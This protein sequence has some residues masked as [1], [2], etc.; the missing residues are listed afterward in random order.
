MPVDVRVRLAHLHHEVPPLQ[1]R[2]LIV[3]KPLRLVDSHVVRQLTIE[4]DVPRDA[5]GEGGL[6]KCDLHVPLE[7]G[8]LRH[9]HE[10]LNGVR[11]LSPNAVGG[12]KASTE[13]ISL[14]EGGREGRGAEEGRGDALRPEEGRGRGAEGE[15]EEGQQHA[16]A[17][18]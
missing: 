9:R 5:Q 6:A 3:N 7:R 17:I 13:A 14:R 11:V 15:G 1:L 18:T 4:D 2:N 16:L 10:Q 12:K 8:P